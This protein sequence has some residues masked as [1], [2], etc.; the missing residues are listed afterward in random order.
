LR[1]FQAGNWLGLLAPART[2]RAIVAR[3]NAATVEAMRNPETRARLIAIGG[4]PVGNSPQEFAAF[5]RTDYEK[6]GVA[7]KQAGLKVD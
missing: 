7:A 3:L 6:N 4:D 2:P 1:G 5:L